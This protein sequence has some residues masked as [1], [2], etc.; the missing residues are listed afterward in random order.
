MNRY[1]DMQRDD[2]LDRGRKISPW[3]LVYEFPLAFL[4][5]YFLRQQF[6][7]GFW[8]LVVAHNYAY[9][10][11]LRIAKMVEHDLLVAKDKSRS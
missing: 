1:S 8:G 4:K 3:R 5:S 6:R 2:M 7:Y 9:S 11:Y 10:R